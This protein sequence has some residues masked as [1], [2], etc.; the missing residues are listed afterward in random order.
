MQHFKQLNKHQKTLN[1]FLCSLS[2]KVSAA[3]ILGHLWAVWWFY[4]W[5]CVVL[6]MLAVFTFR[7]LRVE[8]NW[9][10]IEQTWAGWAQEALKH[11]KLFSIHKL[12]WF[13]CTKCVSANIYGWYTAYLI[14]LIKIFSITQKLSVVS[15]VCHTQNWALGSNPIPP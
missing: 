1:M 10:E 15:F 5:P 7:Q 2:H 13:K 14:Y 12:R 3:V 6:S 11:L 8:L 9:L 4:S